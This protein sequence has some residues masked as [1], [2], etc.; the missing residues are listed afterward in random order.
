[1]NTKSLLIT[2]VVAFITIAVTDFLIHQVWLSATYAETK[3]LWRPEAEMMTKMPL[4]MLGQLIIAAAFSLIFAACVAEKRCLS[5]TLKFSF[6]L[7]LISC[8]G[9]MMMYAVQPIPGSLVVKWCV[10]ITAQLQLL[11]FL[12][13]KVYK[14]PAKSAS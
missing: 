11:G 5:C 10:A 13:H 2:I 4:M 1:M 14:L 8:A 3:H 9:Q 7:A 12:V 6:C